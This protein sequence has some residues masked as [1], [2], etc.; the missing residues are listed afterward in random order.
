M[1]KNVAKL[2]MKKLL[3]VGG[4]LS[5]VTLL[6]NEI[7]DKDEQKHL[8][9]SI[10]EIMSR[11]YTELMVPIIREYPDLDPDKKQNIDKQRMKKKR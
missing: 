1:D 4:S 8:R 3:E 7:D 5:S 10:G 6:V 11:L 9:K 2:L